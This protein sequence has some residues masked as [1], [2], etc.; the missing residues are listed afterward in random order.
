MNHRI[1]GRLQFSERNL[2]MK[3][4]FLN[5][6]FGDEVPLSSEQSSSLP[7]DMAEKKKRSASWLYRKMKILLTI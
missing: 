3:F 6:T 4:V 2:E 7:N 1:E 5:H